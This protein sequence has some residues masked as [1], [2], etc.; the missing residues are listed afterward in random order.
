MQIFGDSNSGNCLKANWTCDLLALPY[1]W[2]EADTLKAES[3]TPDFL[4]MNPAGQ[5]PVG[6][7]RRDANVGIG[8][9]EHDGFRLNRYRTSAS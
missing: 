9:R 3:P 2:I 6:M 4:A 5:V 8:P 1:T 7:L